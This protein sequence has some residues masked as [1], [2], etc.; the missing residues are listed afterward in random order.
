MIRTNPDS[1]PNPDPDPNL[2]PNP[3]TNSYLRYDYN[4]HSELSLTLYNLF[5]EL[6]YM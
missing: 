3:D 6:I 4:L 1:N 5:L 2:N